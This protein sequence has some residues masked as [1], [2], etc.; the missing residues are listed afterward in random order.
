MTGRAVVVLV[1]GLYSHVWPVP[2]PAVVT[3]AGAGLP[4]V[5]VR[6]DICAGLAITLAGNLGQG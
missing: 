4:T 3:G 1:T 2:D 6:T 5:E